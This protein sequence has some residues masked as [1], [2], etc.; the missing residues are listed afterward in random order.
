[1]YILKQYKDSKMVICPSCKAYL[2]MNK[3]QPAFSQ[4]ENQNIEK[5][6]KDVLPE[7]LKFSP[8]TKIDSIEI[9]PNMVKKPVATEIIIHGTINNTPSIEVHKFTIKLESSLCNLCKKRKSSYFEATLQIRPKSEALLNFI[10]KD[11]SYNE[12][13]FMTKV[14]EKKFGYNLNITSKEYLKH[15]IS[16]VKRKFNIETKLSKTLQGRK[17][18]QDVYRYTLLLR[19]KE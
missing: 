6:I 18:G 4:D 10:K 9:N 19:L 5:V 14:E 16:K 1:M 12:K 13:I 8:H 17:D 3:W 11:L 15:V 2:Y 7:R